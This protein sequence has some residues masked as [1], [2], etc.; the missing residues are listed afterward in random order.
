MAM[1][2]YNT[3]FTNVARTDSGDVWWEGLSVEPPTHLIDWRGNDW[4]PRWHTRAAHPNARFTVRASQ[5]PAIAPEWEAP[6]GV[7]IDA[8]LLGGRRSELVPLVFESFDWEHGVFLGATMASETTAAA[9]GELG[10][11]RRDPFAMLPFCGY[12]MGEY[13]SHWLRIGQ[14]HD[15]GKLPRFFSVNWFRK[16]T[17]GGWL[18]PG[19][20]ENSRVLEWIFRRLDGEAAAVETAIGHVPAPGA[21]D[22]DRLTISPAAVEE[23]LRVDPKAWKRE[24]PL[25]REHFARFGEHLPAEL[26]RQLEA[27]ARRLD[28][29]SGV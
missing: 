27:L 21:I 12:N 1:T 3:I 24:L 28:G 19:Y 26:E 16:G 4:T 9:S 13:F 10:V 20:A 2:R 7:P 14:T 22:T 25:L 29:A 18:W 15:V 8:F 6:E 11:V 17:G 5:D 23:L